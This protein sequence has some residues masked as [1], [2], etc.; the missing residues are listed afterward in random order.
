[1][2][3]NVLTVARRAIST[4][5]PATVSA[6][7]ESIRLP[8]PVLIIGSGLGGLTLAHS[9]KKHNIPYRIF[10]R[11]GSESQRAQGYRISLGSGAEE[12]LRSALT[13]ELFD[14]FEKTCAIED[15]VGG[16]VDG[17]SGRVIQ[18]GILGL[19]FSGGWGMIWAL[20]SRVLWKR[21]SRWTWAGTGLWLWSWGELSEP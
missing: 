21:W 8:L 2:A 5:A 12:G 14:K 3:R 11:D 7:P 19:I 13:P 16:R 4:T 17:P 15:P 9:L 18:K 6:G 1:M 10:E 20:G